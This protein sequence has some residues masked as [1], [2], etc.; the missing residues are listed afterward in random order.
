MVGVVEHDCGAS[1][2]FADRSTATVVAERWAGC[3]G[4]NVTMDTSRQPRPWVGICLAVCLVPLIAVPIMQKA[5]VGSY[6]K[7]VPL[8]VVAVTAVGLLSRL[9]LESQI[10][11]RV[12]V[13]AAF[14]SAYLL[15]VALSTAINPT[16]PGSWQS[17]A[18][19]TAVGASVMA[20]GLACDDRDRRVVVNAIIIMAV[21]EGAH[22]LLE[23]TAGIGPVWG[24]FYQQGKSLGPEAFA[25]EIFSGAI[26]AQGSLGHPLLLA[27]LLL[28][29]IA[30]VIGARP[31][32]TSL[33]VL[34][35]LF[36]YA[37]MF[38]TSSRSGIAIASLLIL[39]SARGRWKRALIGIY[40]LAW[41]LL[42]AVGLDLW[43]S[44]V[45]SRFSNSGSV[46]HRGDSLRALGRIFQ[47]DPT[48]VLIGNGLN[49]TDRLYG[50][51]L[52]IGDFFAVDNQF[53]SALAISGVMGAVAILGFL[54]WGAFRGDRQFSWAIIAV[55]AMF[56]TF[57]VLVWPSSYAIM[58]CLVALASPLR[59]TKDA[60]SAH[61][62]LPALVVRH[63]E[64]V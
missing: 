60:L 17:L 64:S 45:L 52:F 19:V 22:G 40:G 28:I 32:R 16:S 55:L 48:Q 63:R 23:V 58:V 9:R 59:R 38:A 61:D 33:N 31:W 25:S 51:G 10:F 41:L 62:E 54:L 5:L 13:P 57:E 36:L 12:P 26:R 14:L 4:H 21:I 30:L 47:Q 56:G 35:L 37:A 42:F 7:S 53:V 39:F 46:A 24:Y 27:F 49:S 2:D 18:L 43:S 3:V 11:Q 15:I 34:T 8:L 44:D 29:G 50:S 6:A 20:L 1:S